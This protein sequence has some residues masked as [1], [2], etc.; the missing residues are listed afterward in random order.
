MFKSIRKLVI[1][2]VGFA[3]AAGLVDGATGDTIVGVIT[4]VLVYLIPND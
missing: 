3:V 2:A 4:S 1:A